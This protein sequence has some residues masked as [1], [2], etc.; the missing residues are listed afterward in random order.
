[1]PKR[2]LEAPTAAARAKMRKQ[3]GSLKSLTVQ[4]VTKAR[5]TKARDDFYAWLRQEHLTLPHS[6]YQ[7][8]LVVSDYLEALW[9]SGKGRTEGSNVLA[10]LQDVQPHLKGQLKMSWRLMKTWSTHEIPN[11]APPLSL[12]C[13]HVM[14]GYSL[15]KV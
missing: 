14:V 6:A 12:E 4:P 13:L 11:R 5:Y 9:A 3:I 10:A 1:M 15:F 7:L 8:D 2:H